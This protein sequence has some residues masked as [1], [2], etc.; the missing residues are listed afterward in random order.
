ML[1]V[2]RYA[3]AYMDAGGPQAPAVARWLQYLE[4]R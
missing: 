4:T 3:K 2:P 1:H